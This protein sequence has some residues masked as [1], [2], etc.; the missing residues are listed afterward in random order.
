MPGVVVVGLVVNGRIRDQ[1]G[2][3]K[4]GSRLPRLHTSRY[5]PAVALIE[6]TAFLAINMYSFLRLLK[7]FLLLYGAVVA[8]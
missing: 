8:Y 4:A 6:M 1:W 5:I 2:N 7:M 3:S